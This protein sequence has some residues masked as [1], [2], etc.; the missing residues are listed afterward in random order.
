MIIYDEFQNTLM[1]IKISIE[2][3]IN[4]YFLSK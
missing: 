2:S 3:F 1:N 4:N